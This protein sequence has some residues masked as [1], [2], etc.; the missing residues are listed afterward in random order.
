MLGGR[1]PWTVL[2]WTVLAA[3]TLYL[4]LAI[5]LTTVWFLER[6]PGGDASLGR[7]LWSAGQ[8]SKHLDKTFRDNFPLY[9]GM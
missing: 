8:F 2:S 9:D 7:S 3:W 4:P 1:R 6:L 5:V